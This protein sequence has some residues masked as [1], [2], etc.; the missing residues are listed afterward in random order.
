MMNL[1]ALVALS[2]DQST[3][4]CEVTNTDLQGKATSGKAVYVRD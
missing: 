4:T 2:A 3:I 1:T